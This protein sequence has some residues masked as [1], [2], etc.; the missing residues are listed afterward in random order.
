MIVEDKDR[1]KAGAFTFA[2]VLVFLWLLGWKALLAQDSIAPPVQIDRV[3]VAGNKVTAEDVILREIP[4]S[5]PKVLS[6]ADLKLIE[7]RVQN[8]RLFNRVELGVEEREGQNV[9]TVL[10][11]ESWYIFPTPVFFVGE[12]E[13]FGSFLFSTAGE[14]PAMPAST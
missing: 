12:H 14:C 10:V 9:L 8:L 4:F 11:T 2:A 5:F 7:N 13:P 1:G 6:A 3:A